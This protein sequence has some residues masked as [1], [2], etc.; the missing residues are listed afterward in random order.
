[1]GGAGSAERATEEYL[2]H[3][4]LSHITDG[5]LAAE[6]FKVLYNHALPLDHF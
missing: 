2:G 4:E 1:M 3:A 5:N 6:N